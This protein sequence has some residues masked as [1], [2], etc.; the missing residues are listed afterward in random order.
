MVLFE[1]YTEL[2]IYR[3]QS[4]RLRPLS[5]HQTAKSFHKRD[6]RRQER[7]D[8]P[9]N[10]VPASVYFPLSLVS[11]AAKQVAVI[12]VIKDPP[13]PDY[14]KKKYSPEICNHKKYTKQFTKQGNDS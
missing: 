6:R 14:S 11:L 4:F 1:T 10:T 2:E 9:T 8:L 7:R 12:L 5:P 3:L 13:L